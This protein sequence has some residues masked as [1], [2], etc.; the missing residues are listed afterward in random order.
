MRNISKFLFCVFTIF[1]LSAKPIDSKQAVISL[2]FESYENLKK[3]LVIQDNKHTFFGGHV[4][5]QVSED[6]IPFISKFMHENYNRCGGFIY[7]GTDIDNLK[8]TTVTNLEPY[9]AP[10][11][12]KINQQAKVIPIIDQVKESS[13]AGSIRKLSSY[14]NRYYKSKHGV[15][16]QNWVFKSWQAIA[17]KKPEIKVEL[18][19]HRNYP[20]PSVVL[21]WTG[22]SLKNE[23]VVLGGHGD[24]IAGW[25]PNSEVNAPGADDNASGIATIT[26]VLTRLV[27]SGFTP[28]RTIKLIS[29]A[30]EEVG[31]RGSKDIAESYKRNNLNVV[32]V[33]QLDM[34][35]YDAGNYDMILISD[36]TNQKQNE[37]L[38]RL[39]NVYLPDLKWTFDKCGYACSDHASWTRNGYPASFPFEAGFKEHNQKI[40][41]A[42]DTIEQS[43]NH[44]HHAVPFAKLALAY[45]IEL[46]LN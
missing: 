31:L 34:T 44:A 20:Q 38:G 32:G 8:L 35:N 15:Q 39:I 13:I 18:F 29:Y 41:T 25:F 7:E 28:D 1:L 10:D 3:H 26:E 37:Y 43:Q 5:L 12:Y 30:A 24:S 40:H 42:K 22:K 4:L 19:E 33:M 36:F 2:D 9:T 17:E 14:R 46:A 23:I 21:T 45:L 11:L 6:D 27:E 16:S